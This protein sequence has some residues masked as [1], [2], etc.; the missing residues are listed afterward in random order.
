MSNSI[1][2]STM[3]RNRLNN[4]NISLNEKLTFF[5][6]KG[7][8]ILK[9]ANYVFLRAD[10]RGHISE[11]TDLCNGLIYKKEKLVCFH[12][13]EIPIANL[14]E[15]KKYIIWDKD[16]VLYDYLIGITGY[17]FWDDDIKDWQVSNDKQPISPYSKLIRNSI[18]NIYSLDPRFTYELCLVQSGLDAG[19]FLVSM[20]DNKVLKEIEWQKI[21]PIA[22]RH[23]FKRPPIYSF[24]TFEDIE[25]P[26]LPLVVM[27]KSMN[28]AIISSI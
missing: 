15:T 5:H 20:Y 4:D 2:L 28:K 22:G 10:K 24:T 25:I 6:E 27:D 3:I 17:L 11:M 14:Q 13:K 26:N 18:F 23:K 12:G 7:I 8:T 16:T 9:E 1:A 21:D 19:L